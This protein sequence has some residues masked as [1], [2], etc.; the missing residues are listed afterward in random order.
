VSAAPKPVQGQS[1][2]KVDLGVYRC[3][4]GEYRA[5][6]V[7]R[8]ALLVWLIQQALRSRAGRAVLARGAIA[9]NVTPAAAPAAREARAA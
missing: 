9:V 5:E 3:P 7:V 8:G 4:R 2:I 1:P 6:L